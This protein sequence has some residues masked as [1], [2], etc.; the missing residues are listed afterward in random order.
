MSVQCQRQRILKVD[1][2]WVKGDFGEQRNEDRIWGHVGHN[3]E[4]L[5]GVGDMRSNHKAKWG[6]GGHRT[7]RLE[8]K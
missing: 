3:R 7:V 4:H 1:L 8:N 6:V 2:T 5:G